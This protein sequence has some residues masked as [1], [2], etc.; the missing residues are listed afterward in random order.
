MLKALS[1]A[2]IIFISNTTDLYSQVS[3]ENANTYHEQSITSTHPTNELEIPENDESSIN[4]N[5]SKFSGEV[6]ENET[7]LIKDSLNSAI[8]DAN[9]LFI[10][11][12]IDAKNH[13]RGY[14][15]A[16]TATL[17]VGLLSPLIG[18]IPAVA[19]SSTP[20][21]DRNLHYPNP[22]LMENEDYKKG[23]TQKAKKIKQSK[24]W[25][26]WGIAFATN[27][28]LVILISAGGR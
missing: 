23:Y 26:N 10:D 17:L 24:V 25:T 1:L 28:L 13:Y 12:Q 19:C 22:K 21:Q 15:G 11:G 9:K 27:L 4:F 6:L 5:T 14:T 3:H 20:P 18:V 7:A 16:G 8:V 2:L